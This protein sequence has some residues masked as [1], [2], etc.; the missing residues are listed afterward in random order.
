MA[1]AQFVPPF[2]RV[3]RGFLLLLA[4]VSL[5]LVVLPGG[6][7]AQEQ[8]RAKSSLLHEDFPFQGA[9][10]SAK[11]PANNIAMKG[12]AIRVAKG[13]DA[14]VL[15][16][17]DLL[18]MAAGWTGGYIT[19]KGVAFDGGHGSHPGIVGEQK[20]GTRQMPGWANAKG[21]FAD[22]RTEPFGPLPAEWCRW[23]GLYVN[24]PDVVLSY[25]VLG[26]KIHEQPEIGRAHV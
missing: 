25:T 14:S 10:V 22:P 13:D 8:R 6:G 23:D 16:D 5:F 21:E 2:V 7:I 4:T 15:F 17:T 24:G 20:F 1:G 9:C 12:L 11:F 19:I 26:T 18:R 3:A